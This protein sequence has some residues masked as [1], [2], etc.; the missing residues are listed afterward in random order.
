[1]SR[2]YIENARGFK[3]DRSLCGRCD[4]DVVDPNF[5]SFPGL[6]WTV[7]LHRSLV[8]TI[9]KFNHQVSR[10]ATVFDALPLS[11][12]Q[13]HFDVNQIYVYINQVYTQV[14]YSRFTSL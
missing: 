13:S 12:D 14:Q 6:I 1:M 10:L 3:I 2:F 4:I 7:L 8:Y 5:I 9:G 11:S